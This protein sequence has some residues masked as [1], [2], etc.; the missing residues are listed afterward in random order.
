MNT[1][2]KP[3]KTD[4]PAI[5]EYYKTYDTQAHITIYNAT[6]EYERARDGILKFWHQMNTP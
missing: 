1:F 4:I 2:Y 6:V 3:P 5:D